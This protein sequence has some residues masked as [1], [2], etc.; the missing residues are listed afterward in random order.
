MRRLAALGLFAALGLLAG[1]SG[2][3]TPCTPRVGEKLGL[4]FVEVCASSSAAVLGVAPEDDRPLPAFWI[5]AAPI[6]CSAGAHETLDCPTVTALEASPVPSRFKNQPVQAAVIDA[7]TAHRLC[8]LRFGGRLP[9]AAEREQARH[10]LGLV[11][12]AVSELPEPRGSIALDE[13]PEWTADG[14]C[15]SS[16]STLAAGCRVSQLPPILSRHRPENDRLLSCEATTADPSLE[17]V[18]VGG[19]CPGAARDG[20]RIRPSCAVRVPHPGFDTTFALLCRRPPAAP[21]GTVA[22]PAPADAAFRCVLPE[23]AIARL[24]EPIEDRAPP[25]APR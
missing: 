25:R 19:A 15:A 22:G 9:T 1:G 7:Q 14:D 16:P 3:D 2:A 23:H 17:R 12:L 5:A 4:R 6:P 21:R 11:S 10:V 18:P 13:L 24:G 20:E 8:T